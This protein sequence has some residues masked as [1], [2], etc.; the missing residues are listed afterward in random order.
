MLLISSVFFV[1]A[2]NVLVKDICVKDI[3]FTFA[4]RT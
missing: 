4:G 2:G 3:C 1:G